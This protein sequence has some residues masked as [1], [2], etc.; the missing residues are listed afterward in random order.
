[1]RYAPGKRGDALARTRSP[2]LRP[3]RLD[4]EPRSTPRWMA[5]EVHFP[6]LDAPAAPHMR[7]STRRTPPRAPVVAPRTRWARQDMGKGRAGRLASS[8]C[9]CRQAAREHAEIAGVWRAGLKP[10]A[11]AGHLAS[12]SPSKARPPR[13]MRYSTRRAPPRAPVMRPR[14]IRMKGSNALRHA[15]C[16]GKQMP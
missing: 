15:R 4:P 9:V 14:A 3:R 11:I 8:V 5:R 12:Y 1:M 7:Q 6:L 16:I 2:M 10:C 13:R